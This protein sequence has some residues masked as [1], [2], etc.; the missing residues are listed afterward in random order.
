MFLM[1]AFALAVDTDRFVVP[2]VLPSTADV[3]VP[4]TVENVKNLVA[5][6]IPLGFSDGVTLEKVEFTDRVKDFEMKIAN[7]DNDNRQVVIGLIAMVTKEAPDMASG[8]GPIANLHFKVSEGVS[9]LEIEPIK[10]TDPS[11]TL[12]YYYNDYSS[13]VPEVRTVYPEM[14]KTEVNISGDGSALPTVYGLSQNFPNP[15]NPATEI[16]YAIPEAGPVKISVFNIL[17]QNVRDLVDD[18]K[19]AGAYSVVWD[20]KDNYGSSVASGVYF[21][22]I[23][24]NNFSDTKKMVLLK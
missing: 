14:E 17:G 6:D 10:L 21:Y 8:S 15:F 20:G 11:H 19:Q 3:V 2:K 24:A 13:G 7:I 1:P 4:L 23:K 12:A 22:R 5:M 16:K 9:T 18:Q